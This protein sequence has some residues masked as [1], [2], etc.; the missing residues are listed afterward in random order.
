L[1]RFGHG[2]VLGEVLDGVLGVALGVASGDVLGVQDWSVN[3]GLVLNSC[4]SM[5]RSLPTYIVFMNGSKDVS[6]SAP[7]PM[8]DLLI[9]LVWITRLHFKNTQPRYNLSVVGG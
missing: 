8:S 2:V 5:V 6:R 3:R 7:W 4:W 1:W 9:L